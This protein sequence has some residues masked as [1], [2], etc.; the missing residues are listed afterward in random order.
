MLLTIYFLHSCKIFIIQNS[1]PVFLEET[2]VR[3]KALIASDKCD[4]FYII[5]GHQ[6][7]NYAN[8]S[9]II[10]ERQRSQLCWDC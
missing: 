3:T 7:I 6:D 1:D 10:V 9:T 8:W 5:T 2:S 4:R